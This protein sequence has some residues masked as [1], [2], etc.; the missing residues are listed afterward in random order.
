MKKENMQHERHI[1]SLDPGKKDFAFCHV[2]GST[3]TDL[4]MFKYTIDDIKPQV[5]HNRMHRFYTQFKKLVKKIEKK[6][7]KITNIV[8]ERFMARPGQGGGAVSESINI[9]LGVIAL[10]CYQNDMVLDLITSASWKNRFKRKQGMD[11]QAARFGFPW[12]AK[13]HLKGNDYPITD[14]NFDSAGIALYCVET[15]PDL[16]AGTVTKQDRDCFK[17]FQK[18]I[19]AIWD[20][21]AKES[22]YNE[23]KDLQR[24]RAAK[25]RA[26]AK[27]TDATT[28]RKAGKQS[29]GRSAETTSKRSKRNT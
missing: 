17:T 24:E 27:T 4:G 6:H 22:G 3:I 13:K 18:Q 14:H 2:V 9:M 26:K 11:T 29:G 21:R 10:Y 19:R 7:G 15:M 28:K 1:L 23:E 25:E 20:K 8:A 12:V 5:F 16:G